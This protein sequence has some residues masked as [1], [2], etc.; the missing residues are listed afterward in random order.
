MHWLGCRAGRTSHTCYTCSLLKRVDFF[1]TTVSYTF[2]DLALASRASLASLLVVPA[3]APSSIACRLTLSRTCS[4]GIRG[5]GGGVPWKTG[6]ESGLPLLIPIHPIPDPAAV[7][8]IGVLGPG[9]PEAGRW[10]PTSNEERRGA[11][12]NGS[13][14]VAPPLATLT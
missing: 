1:R 6:T 8:E 12:F 4:D 10:S 7:A 5:T 9:M 2:P 3:P 13:G 11:R 14:A